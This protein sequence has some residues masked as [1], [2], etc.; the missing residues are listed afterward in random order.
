MSDEEP[1][2]RWWQRLTRDTV[3][4]TVG[5]GLI[6]YEAAFRTGQERPFLIGL[7][8]SMIGLPA[9][10]RADEARQKRNGRRE[11]DNGDNK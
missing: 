5:L 2:G 9:I 4:L 1:R 3:I 7:Y 11:A 10:L 8:A 6:V